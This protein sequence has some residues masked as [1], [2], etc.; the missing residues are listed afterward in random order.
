[1]YYVVTQ[2]ILSDFELEGITRMKCS[3]KNELYYKTLKNL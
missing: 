3:P 2:N 1:M